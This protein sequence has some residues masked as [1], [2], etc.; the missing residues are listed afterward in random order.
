M[1]VKSCIGY[2]FAV[3]LISALM[4]CTGKAVKVGIDEPEQKLEKERLDESAVLFERL[5][6]F[7]NKA[8]FLEGD[9]FV[10]YKDDEETYSFRVHAI[11]DMN[12]K[13]YKL[14]VDEY[15]FKIPLFTLIKN[16]NDVLAI[17]HSKKTYTLLRY[18]DLDFSSVADLN[19]PKEFFIHAVFGAFYV[20][21]GNKKFSS[22]EEHI[23]LMETTE[24]TQRVLFSEEMLPVESSYTLSDKSIEVQFSKFREVESVQFPHKITIRNDE[25]YLK[26]N[27]SKLHINTPLHFSTFALDTSG[28]EEYSRT[29]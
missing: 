5:V 28:L 8:S 26:I 18:E 24:R 4:S 10:I 23:L 29:Q 14:S 22:P 11:A 1:R 25:R 3:V 19:I 15:V 21:E 12:R 9:A 2:V 27:Y 17:T 6:S 13:N 16:S 20:I 7:N